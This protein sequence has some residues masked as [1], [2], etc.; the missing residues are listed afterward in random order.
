M[1]AETSSVIF[2]ASYGEAST[3]AG[4]LANQGA[5]ASFISETIWNEIHQQLLDTQIERL[6]PAQK[7]QGA[8][9]DHW[10]TCYKVAKLDIYLKIRHA[11]NSIL[12]NIKW[13]VTEEQNSTP[14]IR[15][16]VLESLDF[17]NRE[18]L[19]AHR[20]RYESW[21][22]NKVW[23]KEVGN[24]EVQSK[25]IVDI[26]GR[27]VFHNCGAIEN[28]GLEEEKTYVDFRKD[29]EQEIRKKLNQRIKEA[30]EQGLSTKGVRKLEATIEDLFEIFKS[31]LWSGELAMV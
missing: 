18:M 25:M 27:S 19:L 9:G 2:K 28:D 29:N 23:M 31:R 10:L 4:I 21:I 7:I 14:I 1:P 26:L 8:T 16:S 6:Q 22:Y 12:R 11:P 24:K 5:E 17:D 20:D 3:L 13:M 15:R 30:V